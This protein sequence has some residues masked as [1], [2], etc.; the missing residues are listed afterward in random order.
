MFPRRDTTSLLLPASCAAAS[1]T[2]VAVSRAGCCP[3]RRGM[4][5]V[6]LLLASAIMAIV[7]GTLTLLALAVNNT[8]VYTQGRGE[9][10]QHAR[11]IHER[12][13][14]LIQEAYAAENHPGAA[15]LVTHVGT[16]RFP[17]MLLVWR[18]NGAPQNANGPPLIREIVIVTPDPDQPNRLLE[19]TAPLDSR[20][21]PLDSSLQSAAWQAELL[22]LV[23]STNSKRTVLT[24]LLRVASA[25]TDGTISSGSAQQRGAIRF[26]LELRPTA[27]EWSQYRAGS[28]AWSALAWPQTQF[29]WKTGLRHVWLRWELQF[30]P[31]DHV[32]SA[33][34]PHFGS[35]TLTY[36]LNR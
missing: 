25:T 8:A 32:N 24:D 26:E 3:A 1:H 10:T 23:R 11:V 18:P 14:R 35:A 34:I 7:A 2:V 9:T 29:G 22:A 4:T 20:T 28:K 16:W 13:T 33:P 6:E 17:D 19:V 27:A 12:L 5:L 21:I 36:Q 30:A 31:Q 15:V